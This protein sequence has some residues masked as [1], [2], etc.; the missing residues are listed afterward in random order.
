MTITDPNPLLSLNPSV[1]GTKVKRPVS[2]KVLGKSQTPSLYS[3]GEGHDCSLVDPE[4]TAAKVEMRFA[5]SMLRFSLASG[6]VCKTKRGPTL[7]NGSTCKCGGCQA[8]HA[9]LSPNLQDDQLQII[10]KDLKVL[11]FHEL[12][13]HHQTYLIKRFKLSNDDKENLDHQTENTRIKRM[14]EILSR[15]QENEWKATFAGTDL[16]MIRNATFANPRA[17]NRIDCFL[18]NSL[19]PLEDQLDEQCSLSKMTP[20]EALQKLHEK[21]LELLTSAKTRLEKDLEHL[22]TLELCLMQLILSE[23]TLSET[24]AHSSLEEKQKANEAYQASKAAYQTAYRNRFTN[25]GKGVPLFF[26]LRKAL[27]PT[28][29]LKNLEHSEEEFKKAR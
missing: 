2:R 28:A 23:K 15:L 3:K 24:L 14:E 25:T 10:T 11:R 19:R 17:S 5:G 8:A 26:S 9:S 20:K 18:E 12:P 4:S 21:Y 7:Y 27:K 29:S 6:W 22:E 16:D 13:E 1:S